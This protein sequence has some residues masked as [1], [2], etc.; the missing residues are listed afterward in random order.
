MIQL[1][2]GTPGSG[3]SYHAVLDALKWMR[4]YKGIVISNLQISTSDLKLKENAGYIYLPNE[5]IT[6][7]FL[8]NFSSYMYNKTETKKIDDRYLLIIDE[9]QLIFNSRSWQDVTRPAWI[10]FFSQHRHLG[11]KILMLVQYSEMI[12]KQIR[13]LAEYETIHR[14]LSNQGVLGKMLDFLCGFDS[15]IALKIYCPTKRVVDREIFRIDKRIAQRYNTFDMHRGNTDP[16]SVP[17]KGKILHQ[18]AHDENIPSWPLNCKEL[19]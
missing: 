18:S 12:D 13:V 8:G 17:S 19:L 10:E 6:P 3:K 14:T 5:S 1:Y 15:H 16:N 7:S 4:I 9:A 2:T 11:Y